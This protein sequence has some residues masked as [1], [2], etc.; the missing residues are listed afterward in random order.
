MIMIQEKLK[1]TI[2]EALKMPS[3]T[4][5]DIHLEHPTDLNFGDYSSNA[6]L[7]YAKELKTKPID[8][9]E[10]I[11]EEIR[12]REI[13]EIE[14]A[15]VAGAGFINFF[16]SKEFFA[17]S[18]GEAITEG[19]SFGANESLKGRKVMIEY[20][21]PN[22]FKEFH[23]GHLMSNTIGES[24]SR[25]IGFHGAEVKRACYQG[26]VGLHVAKA[27]LGMKTLRDLMPDDKAMLTNKVKFLAMSYS[28]GSSSFSSLSGI[29]DFKRRVDEINKAI[30]SGELEVINKKIYDRN[31]DEINKL[32]D[33]GKDVSL[34]HFGEIYKKL[35]TEFD[36]IFFERETGDFGKKIVEENLKN[37]VFEKSDGAI[38][39]KG[40]KYGLHTRV[41]INSEGLPTYE[42]KELGLAKIKYDEHYQYDVS[43]VVTGNEINDYFKVLL[44]AM[45]IVFPDLAEKT[46]HIS[47]GMLR[48]PSGKMSSRTGDVITAESLMTDTQKLVEEK[49]KDRNYNEEMEKEIIEKVSIGAIKYSILKH[50]TGSDIVYDFDKSISFEGDSGPYLQYSYARAKSVLEKAKGEGIKASAKKVVT[51]TSELERLLYRFPEIVER[52]G[53]EYSPHYI[54]SYLIELAGSFNSFYAKH[55]IVDTNDEISPYKVALT[56]SFAATMKNGLNLLGIQVPERM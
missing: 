8:L 47:H 43:I 2:Q 25:I 49:I 53:K 27:V 29:D 34:K 41:F 23:I 26:D 51:E 36:F 11:A 10:K 46:K 7:A 3:I 31:D 22:P 52:A 44:K 18:V 54:A 42:A 55:K 48:L 13:K 4:A 37:G 30:E 21:D 17:E 6:A 35:G 33:W 9:A 56:A 45:E 12:K 15:E 16:L 32:Y 28:L 20:T 50:T 19:D 24:L 1:N 39:F 14:K 40:E 5:D 38:V